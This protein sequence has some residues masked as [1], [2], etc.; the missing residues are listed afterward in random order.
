MNRMLAPNSILQ[1]RYRIVRLLGEGGMGAVYEAIDE[2]VSCL[3]ALKETMVGP[4]TEARRVFQ[5]EAALLANLRHPSLPKVMDYF[6]EGDSEFLVM[7]FISGHDLAEFLEL[8]GSAF[9]QE[10]VLRWADDVLKVLE[11]LH[12]RKPP[13]LHRDIKPSNLKVTKQGE[14]FLIDFGLAKGAAGQMATLDTSRSV[15]GYTPV[16]APL[17]QI[18]GRGTDP[19]SDLYA[20]GATLYTL[21]TGENPLDAP[22]R[23]AAIDDEQPDPLRPVH[24][25]NPQVSPAVS[26]VVTRAMAIS[27]RQ[28]PS[29]AAEMRQ[30]LNYAK[31]EP[32]DRRD[33][34]VSTLKFGDSEKPTFGDAKPEA[35]ESPVVSESVREPQQPLA[36]TELAPAKVSQPPAP[37]YVKTMAVKPELLRPNTGPIEATATSADTSV[38]ST[39]VRR[40]LPA[41][42]V[43][44]VL[45]VTIGGTALLVRAR[46]SRRAAAAA[47]AAKTAAAALANP[48]A[49]MVVRNPMG[50]ELVWIQPG[51]FTMGNYYY[52]GPEHPVTISNG[53]FMGKYEVAQGQWRTLMGNNPSH[54]TGGDILPVEQV[55]W[56]DA[57][58]FIEKLNQRHDLFTYRLP[59][60][61][62]WEYACRAGTTS[63]SGYD[64]YVGDQAWYQGN[65]RQE[66]HAVGTKLPNAFG[67]FDMRGNVWE[68]CQ[69]WYHQSYDGAP[70]D[71][72][73][74]LSGG[75]QKYRVLRGGSWT[76]DVDTLSSIHRG[77]AAPDNRVN[78]Y[79]FRVVA[80]V[81][82]Q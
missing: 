22:T 11:Y 35:D 18:H 1:N 78:D 82:P 76:Y 5:R 15:L 7:E 81:R 28:R 75:E 17:E 34:E 49:G 51:S 63:S 36:I 39:S 69:D 52:A 66:T 58:Q 77:Y 73:G 20:L 30:A 57:Q 44:L 14:L 47:L 24:E 80:V 29:N 72:S 16:Y 10:R 64:Y 54:F 67:L 38:R 21:L 71:G 33:E 70:A 25:L 61:A 53:F 13:I 31:E 79:G 55:S 74:W 4:N 23:F 37:I 50:M 60:E 27:R 3:V 59:T 12:S 65:S 19:R 40:F 2:R 43:A 42:I 32:K 9:P 46:R 48:K 56:L 68:W 62:E 41:M 26:D 45:L 6:S 8:R